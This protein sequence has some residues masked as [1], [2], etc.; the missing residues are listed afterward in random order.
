MQKSEIR[1]FQM[2][3]AAGDKTPKLE[4]CFLCSRNNEKPSAT[5]VEL[6]GRMGREAC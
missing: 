3:G 2:E 1:A 5:E 4:V 6:R